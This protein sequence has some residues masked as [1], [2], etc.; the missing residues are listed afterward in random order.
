LAHRDTTMKPVILILENIVTILV[1]LVA[2]AVF[3]ITGHFWSSIL[4]MFAMS[5]GINLLLRYL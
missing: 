4:L 2:Y 1:I 3:R 5:A